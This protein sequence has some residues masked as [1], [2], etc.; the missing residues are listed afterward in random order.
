MI[1]SGIAS[2]SSCAASSRPVASGTCGVLAPRGA[3]GRPDNL[4]G[5]DR[6]VALAPT[7]AL[8]ALDL[9]AQPQDP[10]LQRLRAGRTTRNVDVDR[11]ELVGGHKRVGVE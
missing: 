10:V 9:V 5:P 3:V 8:V 6:V 1:E 2:E 7:L 4:L 11:H